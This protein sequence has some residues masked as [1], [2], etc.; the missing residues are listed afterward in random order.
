M[1]DYSFLL[2]YFQA[3]DRILLYGGG[4]KGQK[5]YQ[6]LKDGRGL[7]VV[8]FV[9]RNAERMKGTEV[10]VYKPDE[11]KA[12][13][14]ETY[15][16]IVISVIN[17][18][19]GSE[20]YRIL[21]SNGVNDEKIVAPYTYVGPF[22]K[23]SPREFVKDSLFIRQEIKIFMEAQYKSI[24]YFNPLIKDLKACKGEKNT[25]LPIFKKMLDS[26]TP[27]ES[28]VFLYILYLADI[29]DSELMK[30]LLQS[31]LKIDQPE[32]RVF[33]QGLFFD[34]PTLCQYHE[35][36]LFPEFYNLR[37][38]FL[39][40]ICNMYKLEIQEDQIKR[41]AEGKIQKICILG[42]M[43]YD[44]RDA[45]TLTYIQLSG[46]LAQLGYEVM[47]MPIEACNYE[48]VD[49]P[50]FRALFAQYNGSEEFEEFHKEAFDP[51][52]R[53]EYAVHSDLQIRMQ[54]QLDK[55]ASFS[56]DLI[57]DMSDE[58]STLSYIYSKYFPTLYVPMR[59]YQTCSYYTYFAVAN[60]H[61][62]SVENR[63]YGSVREADA[64]EFP[65]YILFP[66]KSKSEYARED[67]QLKKDDFLLVT[68]GNR[69]DSE[70]T[71]KFTDMVCERLLTKEPIKWLIVGSK[72]K[73]IEKR[74]AD[75][76]AGRKI[77]YIPYEDDL[78]ALY[79]ICDVY[80][81]PLRMG[82]GTSIRWAMCAGL[83][84]ALFSAPSDAIP[85]VG[86]ENTI[87]STE[88]EMAEYVLRLWKDPELYRAE[89]QKFQKRIF[90]LGNVQTENMKNLMDSIESRLELSEGVEKF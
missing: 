75:Y 42:Y 49:V 29:F 51:R 73:Y 50:V 36:Y 34:M 62:F 90:D 86:I 25:L 66:P 19:I 83:P 72:S 59:G 45:C 64:I 46:M 30:V 69:L 82:A 33:L 35:D 70:L 48:Y 10:P 2:R 54:C 4:A 63:K 38:I 13:P 53:V 79:Q 32:L 80:L 6:F 87:G 84:C 71:E 27:L 57:I 81:N 20:I 39:K 8:G 43:L 61:F 60:E 31:E 89:S 5:I 9:D 17:Q 76:L 58:Y 68:V 14:Q 21:R 1:G 65:P 24:W 85:A 37:H 44:R 52:V 40:K 78:P 15:D 55:L 16:K 41:N 88:E 11:I 67:F 26:L 7:E 22:S 56:P 47:V 3:G 12:I 74:Y 18:E 23:I 28:I 77:I